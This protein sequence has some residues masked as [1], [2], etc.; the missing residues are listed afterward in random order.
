MIYSMTGYG[1]GKVKVDGGSMMTEI[2]TVNH[3]FMDFSIKLPPEMNEFQSYIEKRV[4]EKIRRG[5]VYIKVSFDKNT[6]VL[7]SGINKP[8]L[9]SLYRE[10]KKFASSEGIP[11]EVD[12]ASLLSFPDAFR[13]RETKIPKGK[14]KTAIKESLDSALDGCVRMREKEGSI[15]KNDIERNIKKIE[16]SVESI[17]KRAPG[18]IE[19]AFSRSRKRVKEM[20]GSLKIDE[21]RWLTE[22]AIMAD[23]ADFS[24]ELVRLDSH[25]VQFSRELEKGG[26]ISKKLTFMLQEIHREITTLGNKASDTKIINRCLDIK[27]K[28]ERIRE[29]VQNLE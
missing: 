24:E 14:I 7:Q 28:A 20:L 15:L 29:Q 17:K 21:K 23:K 26:Q 12:I 11:G 6:A 25:V 5:R 10:V 18:A 2:R 16:K 13:C 9:K 3:R 22:V 1:K 27:E 8:L 19:R 4:R